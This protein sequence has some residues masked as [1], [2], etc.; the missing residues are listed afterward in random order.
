[1]DD[2]IK[3]FDSHCHLDMEE[4]DADRDEV[5]RRA[6]DAGVRKILLAA[7]DEASSGEIFRMASGENDSGVELLATAGVHPHEASGVAGG[8][9]EGLVKLSGEKKIS[10]IGEIG[11]DYYYDNSPRKIQRDVFERQ[12][13]LA[14]RA[15]KPVLLH[16]RNAKSRS[17]GDAYGEA[18]S[19]IKNFPGLIGGVVH[20]F[21]G[22]KSD[23]RAALDLGFYVSFAGPLTYPKADELREAAKY[24]PLD[25]I[26]CETDAPYLA[27]QSKRGRRNE[28]ALVTDVYAKLA[29]VK[30]L[31]L[32]EAAR[33]VWDNGVRLFGV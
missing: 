8:L 14:A 22:D 15:R 12:L 19:V 7:C 1:M 4:F 11:L 24:S 20:C 13:D 23:A 6:M 29:E 16:L 33:A 17:D 32:G 26:L 30:G 10:A 28:P 25:R 9:P 3:F 21:S 18:M 2:T 31:T 27:P 5:L